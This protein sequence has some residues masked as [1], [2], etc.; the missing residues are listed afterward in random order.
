[1]K[2][3]TL[4]I[5]ITLIFST[6]ARSQNTPPAT[7]IYLA[8]LSE[9][10]GTVKVG[11]PA[12]ITNREGYDNQPSFMRDGRSI[13]YT[14]I[15]EDNQADIYRYNLADGSTARVIQTTDS[16]YSPTITPDGKYFS[17]IRVEKDST[18]RLWKFPT[19]GGEPSL[20]LKEI[21]PVGYHV[22]IDSRTLALFILGNPNSLQ[23]VDVGTE[24][25][26]TIASSIGRSLHRRPR[27]E[28]IN[29]VRKIS[30]QEWMIEEMDIKTRKITPLIKTLPASEDFVWTP[31]GTILMAKGAKLYSWNPAKDKDWKEAG[32]FSE[33]GMK[34]ITRLAVSPAG[35]R[36]AM[37]ASN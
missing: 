30:D 33:Y 8:E 2:K 12:N 36:L 24:K 35:E 19:G 25:A 23:V 26:E 3:V 14:S 16:E 18:Q 22:W 1:M 13:L 27:Q 34:S 10:D 11:K 7:E 6:L 17:V 28:K 21:K 5:L 29:F 4:F 20:V 37:V 31:A 9:K 32:D 15:R